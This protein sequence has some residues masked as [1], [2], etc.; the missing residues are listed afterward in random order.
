MLI[1]YLAITQTSFKLHSNPFW[2]TKLNWKASSNM[3]YV[4][5]EISW[6]CRRF[7]YI[8]VCMFSKLME[9]TFTRSPAMELWEKINSE[10]IVIVIFSSNYAEIPRYLW[11]N[12]SVHWNNIGLYFD[13]QSVG[14]VSAGLGLNTFPK[15]HHI[16]Q[17]IIIM[18][19][20]RG[21]MLGLQI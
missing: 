21:E 18:Y 4:G 16:F 10:N 11:T 15:S 13:I 5:K 8:A 2:K 7:I 3:D 6:R 19:D 17:K 12:C 1:R 9:V 14:E 20:K